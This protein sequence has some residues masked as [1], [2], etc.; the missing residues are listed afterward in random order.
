MALNIKPLYAPDH[1]EV[2]ANPPIAPIKMRDTDGGNGNRTDFKRKRLD[3]RPKMS[4]K[5]AS[6]LERLNII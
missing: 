6:A 3:S 5:L 2:T 4:A 1:P